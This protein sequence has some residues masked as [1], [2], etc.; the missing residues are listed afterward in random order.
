MKKQI[1]FAG[2][3]LAFGM[4][5]AQAAD[6]AAG[7]T[8]SGM[9]A[10]CHGLDG[11]SPAPMFPK[12]AGQ[13][14]SYLEKQLQDFKSQKRNDP[15][16]TGMAA[17]LSDEDIADLSAYYASQKKTLEV[18]D[19]EKITLGEKLY[20]GGNPET[21]L[22]ACLSCH[23]PTGSGNEPAGFPSLSGQHVTYLEKSLNDFKSEARTNDASEMMRNTAGKMT[24][25]EIKAVSSYISGLH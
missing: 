21:G 4:G 12:L 8:K 5:A 13:H 9:C 20:R 25:K 15:T 22:A 17:A 2:L 16:M 7:K 18:A 19:V 3:I 14:A 24:L 6:V 10:A 23:S 1:L 11:N